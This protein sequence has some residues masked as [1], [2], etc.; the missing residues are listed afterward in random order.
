MLNL[1]EGEAFYFVPYDLE[2]LSDNEVI[3]YKNNDLRELIS[4]D[5]N[6]RVHYHGNALLF[7]NLSTEDSGTYTAM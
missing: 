3:W 1:H 7:L 5:E 6:Q 2:D 4:T